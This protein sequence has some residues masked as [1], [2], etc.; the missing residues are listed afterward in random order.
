MINKEKIQQ[1]KQ[2][3]VSIMSSNID[4]VFKELDTVI[5]SIEEGESKL[6]SLSLDYTNLENEISE[7]R[8]NI[9]LE[10]NKLNR[11]KAE[12]LEDVNNFKS[13]VDKFEKRKSEFEN[14]LNS[15][16]K[17][18]DKLTSDIDLLN[19]ELKSL[20][21]K[22]KAKTVLANELDAVKKELSDKNCSL[23]EVLEKIEVLKTDKIKLT[24][25][26]DKI[27]KEIEEKRKIVLPTIED[28]KEREKAILVKE[29]DL[30][31][32]IDRYKKLYGEKGS[33]FNI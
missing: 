33:G 5:K 16:I 17:T 22:I 26:L 31:I 14:N 23:K 20:E 30:K 13:Q 12:H 25:E 1:T 8:S 2:T 24:Q 9:Q 27:N 7:I 10:M 18:K 21:T 32:I 4:G 11:N 19:K 3:I 15:Y 29:S 28:L 6:V